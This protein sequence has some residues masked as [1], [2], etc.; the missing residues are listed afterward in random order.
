MFD[1]ILNTMLIGQNTLTRQIQAF[2]SYAL[3]SITLILSIELIPS[4]EDFSRPFSN[5]KQNIWGNLQ[6]QVK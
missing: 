6:N 5:Q 4:V 3:S 2:L 1:R